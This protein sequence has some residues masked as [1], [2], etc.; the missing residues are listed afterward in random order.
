M[1][2]KNGAILE[3]ILFPDISE[4]HKSIQEAHMWHFEWRYVMDDANFI[5]TSTGALC[6]NLE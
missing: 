1:C 2:Q 4:L 3:L 6:A 5:T